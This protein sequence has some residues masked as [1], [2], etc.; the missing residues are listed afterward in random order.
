MLICLSLHESF[1]LTVFFHGNVLGL[2]APL[3]KV[4][5]TV[6]SPARVPSVPTAPV[7]SPSSSGTATDVEREPLKHAET[8]KSPS[9]QA[10]SPELLSP[11]SLEMSE[12][13][14]TRLQVDCQQLPQW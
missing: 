7:V 1:K 12:L 9:S 4:S 10:L 11:T 3:S 2:F 14:D 13:N 6:N 8:P 5:K